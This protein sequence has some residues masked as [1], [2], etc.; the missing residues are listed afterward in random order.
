MGIFWRSNLTFQIR[1]LC[2][3]PWMDRRAVACLNSWSG[4]PLE[5]LRLITK[6]SGLEHSVAGDRT[7]HEAADRSSADCGSERDP[8]IVKVTLQEKG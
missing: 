6:Q 2:E 5:V 4:R 8:L 1:M 7:A 3:N